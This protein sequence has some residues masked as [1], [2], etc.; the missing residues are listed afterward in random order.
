MVQRAAVEQAPTSERSAAPPAG[1]SLRVGPADD[2]Y[3]RQADAVAA[4]VIARLSRSADTPLDLEPAAAPIVVQRVPAEVGLE[5]GDLAPETA[6]EIDRARGTGSPLDGGVRTSMEAAFGG[7]DFSG[8]RVH[9][10]TT[11]RR[12]NRQLAAKAF[13]VGSDIFF[14]GPTPNTRSDTGRHLLAHELTHTLQQGSASTVVRAVDEHAAASAESPAVTAAQPALEAEPG[15]VVF[16]LDPVVGDGYTMG[17]GP[18]QEDASVPRPRGDSPRVPHSGADRSTG[19]TQLS[20]SA[21]ISTSSSV[22]QGPVTGGEIDDYFKLKTPGLKPTTSQ[23]GNASAFGEMTPTYAFSGLE[24]AYSKKE[25][26]L[27]IKGNVEGDYVWGTNSGN[28]VDVPS[29]TDGVVTADNYE[30]IVADLTPKLEEKCW[31]APRSTYWSEAICARHEKYHATDEEKWFL[32]NGTSIIDKYLKANP[33]TISD[34]DRKDLAKVKVLAQDTID[35]SIKHL[36]AESWKFYAGANASYCT[37]PGEIRAF[38]DGKSPYVKLASGVKAQG[39]KLV[40][41]KNAAEKAAKRAEKKAAKA[42]E[43]VP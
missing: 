26:R 24:V 18:L 1:P 28:H 5:G 16:S 36:E 4:Q 2:H 20:W 13:T 15:E 42:S 9:T 39:K 11:A 7:A 29:A 33:V 30:Q 8:I 10:G 34:T 32:K 37:R 17:A 6:T 19:A 40:K 22:T 43:V 41:A 25:G 3:E 31:R 38:G 14:A 35:A 23:T 21:A 12:L 27:R